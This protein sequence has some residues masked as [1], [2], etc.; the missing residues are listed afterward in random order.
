[1]NCF[2]EAECLRS[3]N[4]LVVNYNKL[5]NANS[6]LK[7]ENKHLQVNLRTHSKLLEDRK[8]RVYDI[9]QTQIEREKCHIEKIEVLKCKLCTKDND[10]NTLKHKYNL[11]KK[12]IDK[13][14]RELKLIKEKYQNQTGK[15]ASKCC[16]S[17]DCKS[18]KTTVDSECSCEDKCSIDS[19]CSCS[20]KLSVDSKCSSENKMQIDS[21][22]S[23]DCR[24][25]E[26]DCE[27]KI[28]SDVQE[29]L[30]AIEEYCNSKTLC[31]SIL[32]LLGQS[33]TTIISLIEENDINSNALKQCQNDLAYSMKQLN[34]QLDI[35]K[36]KDSEILTMRSDFTILVDELKEIEKQKLNLK[37]SLN[38]V[39]EELCVKNE[40]HEQLLNKFEEQKEELN[41]MKS[42][43]KTKPCDDECISK[44]ICEKTEA[45]TNDIEIIDGL[46]KQLKETENSKIICENQC[47]NMCLKNEELENELEIEKNNNIKSSHNIE[48]L[49]KRILKFEAVIKAIEIQNKS[50]IVD[51]AE[52]KESKCV[53]EK[54]FNEIINELNSTIE[55]LRKELITT[56]LNNETYGKCL[57]NLREVDKNDFEQ[58]INELKNNIENLEIELKYYKSQHDSLL[59]KNLLN[60]KELSQFFEKIQLLQTREFELNKE[61][62]ENKEHVS[63]LCTTVDTLKRELEE[64]IQKN[65]KL[66]CQNRDLEAQNTVHCEDIDT[67]NNTI[68]CVRKNESCVRKDLVV[69]KEALLK[70]EDT[71]VNLN[72]EIGLVQNELQTTCD[73]LN[74]TKQK[75]Y[76]TEVKLKEEICLKKDIN[77]KYSN[78]VQCLTTNCNMEQSIKPTSV[79]STECQYE[80]TDYCCFTD[81]NN[82]NVT[83]DDVR[84]IHY[85]NNCSVID[86][87]ITKESTHIGLQTNL[88]CSEMCP[89]KTVSVII[90]QSCPNNNIICCPE[91]CDTITCDFGQCESNDSCTC[92][93]ELPLKTT[94]QLHYHSDDCLHAEE[95]KLT[96]TCDCVAFM[97]KEILKC[98]LAESKQ[99]LK[100]YETETETKL[101]EIKEERCKKELDM[102]ECFENEKLKYKKNLDDVTAQLRACEEKIAC[103]EKDLKCYRSRENQLKKEIDKLKES[104]KCK[105]KKI[106]DYD[107]KMNTLTDCLD[108]CKKQ[109]VTLEC[110]L[111]LEK[112]TK[113][114]LDK[115]LETFNSS[116]IDESEMK[117]VK[118]LKTPEKAAIVKSHRKSGSVRK[119]MSKN[120]FIE[121]KRVMTPCEM[122]RLMSGADHKTEY[123]FD[124]TEQEMYSHRRS[125]YKQ[126]KNYSCLVV[127]EDSQRLGK[128]DPAEP[129]L[130]AEFIESL[131]QQVRKNVVCCNN[132]NCFTYGCCN[133][134]RFRR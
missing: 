10:I 58:K 4:D 35:L 120:S 133:Q 57:E 21:K 113:L 89:S 68:V 93:R 18:E 66:T 92:S 56:K 85:E 44:E 25:S 110:S 125:G 67:L 19:K 63:I 75:L 16:S 74:C 77:K 119:K 38:Q 11:N 37:N 7:K 34:E 36:E 109:F 112:A 103:K 39:Q 79:K 22:C 88:C 80:I 49:C 55:Q 100:Q 99:L 40:N 94:S 31:I 15:V 30:L 122:K 12:Q 121:K 91:P 71:I 84:T 60:E 87:K 51:I 126:N 82:T 20:N 42:C 98:Q 45:L 128:G 96:T 127:R 17:N 9:I 78:M 28:Y 105:D 41:N 102:N 14:Q 107:S 47:K 123:D 50:Y 64:T 69:Y 8:Y 134:L 114:E 13:Y 32:T 52:L 86:Y 90:E 104:I 6:Y 1:M 29:L 53:A 108:E 81:E 72:S 27:S 23:C 130:P 73:N 65:N 95:S 62:E 116:R 97:E 131:R 24:N 118:K 46:E 115:Q 3:Y 117:T 48:N 2:I 129:K 101:S 59:T 33:K 5:F 43:S 54:K 83:N 61:N 111:E 106:K 132:N 70:A 26:K 124:E 76:D